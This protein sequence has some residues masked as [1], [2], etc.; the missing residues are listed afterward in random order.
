MRRLPPKPKTDLPQPN[1]NYVSP[2]YNPESLR[3]HS[4]E[5]LFEKYYAAKL[6]KLEQEKRKRSHN[7]SREISHKQIDVNNNISNEDEKAN[8]NIHGIRPVKKEHNKIPLPKPN[9]G[10]LILPKINHNYLYENR[11]IISEGKVPKKYHI[12]EDNKPQYHKDFGK[13]P[14][15]LAQYKIEEERRKEY[16]KLKE[17]EKT[18][19]KGT[20]LVPD[21]ERLKTL[22]DLIQ[23]KQEIE[24]T[25]EKMPIT[26]RSLAVQNK[27][28][29]LESK[30]EELDKAIEL[31][32]KKR[33]F[34]RDQ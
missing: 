8:P 24:R 29:E 3:A 7:I 19:P 16:E 5:S 25:L 27:K 32:S 33:V 21:Q 28:A 26:M 20:R 12:K 13:T 23:A 11:K 17:E 34:V 18:Y 10:S 1:K 15:Y 22:Q 30:M 14:E 6:K 9:E 2:Y 4:Q 31:F